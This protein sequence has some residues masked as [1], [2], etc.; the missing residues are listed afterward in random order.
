[1]ISLIDVYPQ[2]VVP[3]SAKHNKAGLKLWIGVTPRTS[4]EE[5][6]GVLRISTRTDPD[7]SATESGT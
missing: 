6:T 5:V 4:P 3:P 7:S 2:Y 1:M